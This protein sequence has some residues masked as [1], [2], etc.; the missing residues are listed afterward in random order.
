MTKA[1]LSNVVLQR[2]GPFLKL[3][4]GGALNHWLKTGER[5]Q[6]AGFLSAAGKVDAFISAVISEVSREF[7][8]IGPH[9]TAIAPQTIVSVG[10]G[11]GFLEYMIYKAIPARLVLIDI[12]QSSEHRHGF[13]Q[14]GS[15]Y[16]RL[17]SCRDFLISNGVKP[18]HVET[19][20]PCHEPLPTA[21][22]DIL[23]SLFSM[24][25]HYPC[26]EYAT[27]VR[28][29]LRK[30]GLLIFDKRIDGEDPGWKE[31][32]PLFDVVVRMESIKS[33]RMILSRNGAMFGQM[34]A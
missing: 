14:R 15:G 30:G 3:G 16:S 33:Q 21:G 19:C 34:M 17:A 6:L 24:G 27:F 13:A 10:P 20:N 11:A 29:G 22:F 8:L 28:A 23:I 25:F 9:I 4:G 31:L 12:E 18:E 26:D 1:D 5:W 2:T 7:E 32:E